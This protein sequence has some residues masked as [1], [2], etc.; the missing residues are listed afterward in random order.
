MTG[1]KL[2]LDQLWTPLPKD[3]TLPKHV[4]L[5]SKVVSKSAGEIIFTYWPNDMPCVELNTYMISLWHKGLSLRNR[6]GTLRTYAREISHLL[7]YCYRNGIPFNKLTDNRFSLF[8][9]N[10]KVRDKLG[11]RIRKDNTVL[12]IGRRSLCFLKFIESYYSMENFVGVNNC[13]ITAEEKVFIKK[14]G[15]TEIRNIY[16]DHDSFPEYDPQTKKHP[17]PLDAVAK[18]KQAARNEPDKALSLRKQCLIAVVEQSGSRRTEANDLKVKDVEQ[19]K[20]E[21]SL[22]PKLMFTNVKN[23]KKHIKHI[24]VPRVLIDLLWRYKKYYRQSIINEKIKKGLLKE[25]HGYFF[26][27]HTEGTKLTDDTITTEISLLC[28]QA[29]LG[30]VS[31]HLHLFR[32]GFITQKLIVIILQYKIKDTDEFRQKILDTESFKTELLEWTGQNSVKSLDRYVNL[33]FA[34][35]VEIKKLY[36]ATV[37]KSAAIVTIDRIKSVQHNLQDG[38][39]NADAAINEIN[40]ILS[41]FLQDIDAAKG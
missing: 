25:D 33:A 29:N 3:F 24:P 23:K 38:Y 7:K 1:N 17:V 26:I 15:K 18:L 31:A 39:Y 12:D 5:D 40:S 37:L 16:W 14:E 10:L 21:N 2:R 6:G 8:I 4:A 35:V 22:T 19:A 41:S 28:K 20:N 34:E 11:I 32:H 27:S 36:D 30:E 9:E 13:T